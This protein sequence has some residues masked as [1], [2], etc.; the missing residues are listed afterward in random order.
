MNSKFRLKS[1]KLLSSSVQSS[2]LIWWEPIFDILSN[3]M[4]IQNNS[5]DRIER[6]YY[7]LNQQ[8]IIKQIRGNNLAKRDTLLLFSRNNG[9]NWI[10]QFFWGII[11]QVTIY[12]IMIHSS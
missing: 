2:L 7:N 9:T 6:I 10:L 8:S 5:F 12:F 11:L 1:I 3:N 4:F